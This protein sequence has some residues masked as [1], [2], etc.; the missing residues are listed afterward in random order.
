MNVFFNVCHDAID[1]ALKNKTFGLYYSE[2]AS[3]SLN[4]HVHDCCEIFLS[5]SEGNSFLIDDKVYP[6]NANDLFIINHF[7]AHK[8]SP[9]TNKMFTRFSLHVHPSF[10]H[11]SSSPEI[12][13][14]N[15]FY[16]ENK[17]DKISLTASQSEKF[18]ELFKT[19]SIDYG[20]ADDLYK[21][22]RVIEI[23]IEVNKLF[24]NNVSINGTT[25]ENKTLKLAIDYINQNFTKQIDLE[26]I[27]K[28]CFVSVNQLCMIFKHHLST[29]VKKYVN[30]KRITQAKKFLSEGKS[31]TETAFA[32]GFNDIIYFIHVFKKT[33][34][35]SPK[36]YAE[37]V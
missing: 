22:M 9:C 15:C 14:A 32:C 26:E 27:A 29:T 31:V 34:G 8:V 7:Q 20:Y 25:K 11:N 16:S 13:L 4:I 18:Q 19:L 10:I 21:K 24:S 2:S 35:V 1:C 36:K 3:P 30:S 6:L 37:T 28:N 23:L 33:V 12:D 5:L 17:A